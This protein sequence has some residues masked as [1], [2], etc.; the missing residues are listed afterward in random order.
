MTGHASPNWTPAQLQPDLARK[1]SEAR[2]AHQAGNIDTAGRL[3]SEILQHRPDEF[4][5]LH[6]LGILEYQLGNFPKALRLMAAALRTN[7]NC[8]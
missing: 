2:A 4:D 7:G 1:L 5:A 3:Y 8:R 6:M